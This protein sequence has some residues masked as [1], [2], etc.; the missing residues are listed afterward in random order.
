MGKSKQIAQLSA[1]ACQIENQPYDFAATSWHLEVFR[2]IQKDAHMVGLSFEL[3]AAGDLQSWYEQL[4]EMVTKEV[5][6]GDIRSF[7]YRID[8]SERKIRQIDQLSVD[9]LCI[10]VLEREFKKVCIRK[11]FSAK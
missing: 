3:D 6:R 10:L 5:L 1:I 8:V 7:L 4:K 11:H 2:Q 9:D